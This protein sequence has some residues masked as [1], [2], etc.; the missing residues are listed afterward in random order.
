MDAEISIIN[1]RRRDIPHV[2]STFIMAAIRAKLDHIKR[3]RGRRRER[4]GKSGKNA[5]GS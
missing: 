5:K 2:R 4:G 3:C 1:Q